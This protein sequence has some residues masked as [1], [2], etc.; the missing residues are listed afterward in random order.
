MRDNGAPE[1]NNMALHACSDPMDIVKNRQ[2]LAVSLGRTVNDF[3]C[4]NQTHSSNF[5]KV[6]RSDCGRGATDQATAIPDTDALYTN[7]RG[8]V[9]AGFTADCV[10]VLLSNE[11]AG[12]VGVVHSGWQG[13][14]KEITPKLLQHLI[15][16][17]GCRP[18]DFQIMIGP[19]LSQEKFEVDKDVYA[20]FHA[21]GYAEPWILFNETTGKYHIDNQRTVKTQCEL[22]GIPSTNITID[23]MC[24]F[25]SNDG[26]SYRQDKKAGRHLAFI[27][28]K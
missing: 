23:P 7:E 18:E 4:A 10:P 3:V 19:A 8:I 27:G 16:Q 14:I 20:K 15:E 12:I 25:Q 28:L 2:A 26:F 11:P 13:T 21:L 17:E 1:Q 22:A 5:H 6:T 9:L 24:T